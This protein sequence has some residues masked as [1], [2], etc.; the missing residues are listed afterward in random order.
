MSLLRSFKNNHCQYL[1][2]YSNYIAKRLLHSSL[3]FVEINKIRE[4][5]HVVAISIY[6][7]NIK[8]IK[9]FVSFLNG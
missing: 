4:N 1:Q 7:L 9:T 6:N 8:Q 2:R 5:S 3:I